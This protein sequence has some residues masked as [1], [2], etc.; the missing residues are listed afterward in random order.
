[1]DLFWKNIDEAHFLLSHY[2]LLTHSWTSS[3]R[4]MHFDIC[5]L[6]DPWEE[7]KEKFPF[8][9]L[10]MLYIGKESFK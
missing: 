10:E 1:M 6:T 3:D 7:E 5:V 9:V 8:P 4:V 2:L